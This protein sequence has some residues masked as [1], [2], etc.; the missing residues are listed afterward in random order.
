MPSNNAK[1][2][3]PNHLN[4]SAY[5]S[6]FN[7]NYASYAKKFL[8]GLSTRCYGQI[9]RSLR[10]CKLKNNA[11]LKWKY[12]LRLVKKYIPACYRTFFHRDGCLKTL[13]S[14][15]FSGRI[16]KNAFHKNT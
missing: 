14:F 1:V 7:R 13:N 3:K 4:L 2:A 10:K 8:L 6:N 15:K 16:F 5:I 11:F 12:T 9:I